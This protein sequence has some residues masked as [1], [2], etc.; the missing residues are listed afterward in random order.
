MECSDKEQQTT[1]W[2]ELAKGS[3]DVIKC[4]KEL[5]FRVMECW[6]GVRL[7]AHP[8]RQGHT[9]GMEADIES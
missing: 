8:G 7:T 3:S 2:Q 5:P 6:M 1:H 4:V 9:A